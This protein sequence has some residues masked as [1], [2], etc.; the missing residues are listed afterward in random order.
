V[1][2]LDKILGKDRGKPVIVI[3]GLPRSG[4]SMAMKMVEAAG[5]EPF[6][7][8]VRT[9]DEDNPKGYY[10]FEQV[11]ELDKSADK[12]WVKKARGRA[13][14][15]ISYLLKDLPPDNDYR[16]IFLHRN[17][18]EVLRSQSKMLERRG[19]KSD[20]SDE[21]MTEIYQ[22]HLREVKRTLETRREFTTLDLQYSDVVRDAATQAKR[23]AEFLELPAG[24]A[25][26]MAEQVDKELYR[27]RAG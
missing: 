22:V 8:G 23:I 19:E 2:I 11:K 27:N 12:T 9:A 15:V 26:T 13:L 21:R 3:S 7:D 20:V 10:E 24:A 4:T 6:Q 5:I 14:K 25:Q 17:L 18:Q 1:S 16:V